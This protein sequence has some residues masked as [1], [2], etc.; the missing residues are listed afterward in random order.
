[1]HIPEASRL[2]LSA[3]Y[4]G[5]RFSRFEGVCLGE[6]SQG[7]QCESSPPLEAARLLPGQGCRGAKDCLEKSEV[8]IVLRGVL[9]FMYLEEV[10]KRVCTHT[11]A[12]ACV[13]S[14]GKERGE[15]RS[16]DMAAC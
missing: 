15:R 3:P 10:C 6:H 7:P 13:G 8:R 4:P 16:P 9:P 5:G 1:M 12:H 11:H 2:D 14:L